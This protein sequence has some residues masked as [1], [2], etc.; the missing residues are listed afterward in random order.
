MPLVTEISCGLAPGPDVAAHARLAE[1][2]RYDRVWLYDSPAIYQDVWSWLAVIGRET[3]R[4]GLGTAVAV[5]HLRHLMAT[6]S[7]IATVETIAPGRLACGFGTGAS[8]RWT[9]GKSPLTLEATGGYLRALRGLLAGEVV[10]VDGESV[11]MIHLPQLAPPRPITVPILLSA[12]GPKGQKLAAEVADGLITVGF[13]GDGWDWSAQLVFGTVLE[14]GETIAHER[15]KQAVGP[16]YTMLAYHG[17]YESD[18]AGVDDA[19]AGGEWRAAVEEERPPGQRHLVVHEG[20]AT[21]VTARDRP[22]VDAAGERLAS[23]G[24]VGD[25]ETIRE[26]IKEAGAQGSTEVIYAPAGPDVSRELR[27]FARAAGRG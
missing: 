18:P 2:L 25:A 10:D 5:P 4:V 6:A 9:L 21:H 24:W 13:A 23:V 19:P 11:Q 1:E 17:R 7:A 22:L 20:H 14:D 12:L 15:V 16:W 8:S 3:D 26:R 27:A